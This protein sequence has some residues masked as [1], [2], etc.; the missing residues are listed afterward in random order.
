MKIIFFGDSITEGERNPDNP[1]DLGNGYVKFAEGKLRLLYPETRM[2]FLNRG[3]SGSRIADLNARLKQDVLDETPDVVVLQA[4]IND[5]LSKFKGEEVSEEAF[6]NEYTAL[7]S[8][9]TQAGI[10]VL[11]LQPFALPIG[12][13]TR[14]RP[15][16]NTFNKII[17]EVAKAHSVSVIPMDEIFMGATQDIKPTQF[18]TD[19]I[20]PTHRGH[21]YHA[22]FVI[23]ELKKQIV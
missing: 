11:V 10:K 14:L 4:G 3:V 17:R 8:A 20:H 19:G 7:L 15:R 1:N 12:D 23:K 5:V 13:K 22:D 16:L 9:L 18:S 21:R 6:R 2:Q